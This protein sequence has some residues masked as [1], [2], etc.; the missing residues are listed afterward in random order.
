MPYAYNGHEYQPGSFEV[1]PAGEYSVTINS[2]EERQS[3]AGNEMMEIAVQVS[4]GQHA[5]RKLWYYIVYDDYALNKF[6]SLLSSLGMDFSAE[7]QIRPSDLIGKSGTVKVRHRLDDKG[8]ERAE[9][10][11][12]TCPDRRLEQPQPRRQ[13]QPQDE[14]PPAPTADAEPA[15]EDDAPEWCR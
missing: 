4:A 8:A 5:G 3:K 15:D 14:E 6:G 1:L 12:W 13:M 7:M 10:H 9:I 11:Y 2:A